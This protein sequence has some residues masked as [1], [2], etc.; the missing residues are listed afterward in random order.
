[1]PF[2]LRKAISTGPFRFNLSK[3]GIGL[4]VGVKGLR[5]GTGPRGNY[6]YAGRG[7]LYYR[8]SLGGAGQRIRQPPSQYDGPPS[9]QDG[10]GPPPTPLPSP[11]YQDTSVEMVEVYSGDVL[12]MRDAQFSE[13]VDELNQKQRQIRYATIFGGV[14]GGL[15]LLIIPISNPIGLVVLLLGLP[16]WAI[17]WWLDSYKRRS[18]LFYDLD[19][20]AAKAYEAVTKAFDEMM[21]CAG[22]WHIEAKGAIHDL[23]TWKRNAGASSIVRR[24]SAGLTYAAPKV[25]ASNI[26][27]PSAQL[28]RQ[29]IYF[30]PD[31]AFVIDG[32]N[33]GA[34]SYD[35]ISIH[36]EGFPFIETDTVPAD[37][38]VIRYTWKYPNKDGGPDR[39]FSNNSQIPVCLYELAELKSSS[40][41]NELFELSRTGVVEPFANAI[42]NLSL[43]M[44]GQATL[45]QA[46]STAAEQTREPKPLDPSAANQKNLQLIQKARQTLLDTKTD[47]SRRLQEAPNQS[48]KL[49]EFRTNLFGGKFDGFDNLIQSFLCTVAGVDGPINAQ[50]AAAINLIVGAQRDESFYN[51]LHKTVSDA[52]VLKTFGNVL[53]VAIEL[54]GIEQGS[55]YDAESDPLIK[56]LETVG[57][58]VLS[59]D[60]NV[61]QIELKSLSQ[62]TSVAKSKASDMARR[63]QSRK[64]ASTA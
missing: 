4:S 7:G 33:V 52:E 60:G 47:L 45:K 26:T 31:A 13:L 29:A 34:I 53:D 20:D 57:L 63:I 61:N 6:I 30:F 59:A 11:V 54:S 9:Q 58:A 38:K 48:A 41:L 24:T 12:A 10:A 1:M 40:G 21:S 44:S 35:N 62:F 42:K 22:K 46:Q 37:A 25:I 64:N 50:E 3:S 5:F 8:K 2:F 23:A 19:E 17:G 15:G 51:D 16:A 39:R 28:G 49:S 27:P 14:I 43:H 55:A 18:V 32:K 56:C 36:S